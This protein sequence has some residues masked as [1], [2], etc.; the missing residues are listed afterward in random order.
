MG[1]DKYNQKRDFSKTVEPK[2]GKSDD[3]NK[4]SFVIQKHH[5]FCLEI[6]V[7]LKSSAVPKGPTLDS[8]VWRLTMMV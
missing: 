6:E 7:V 8:K 4:L 2:A 3:K 5:D 1:L